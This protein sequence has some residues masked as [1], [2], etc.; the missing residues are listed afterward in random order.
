MV[1]MVE[2]FNHL[3][4]NADLVL[5]AT[6]PGGWVDNG[7]DKA[8]EWGGK[9]AVFLGTCCFIAALWFLS[10]IIL[11]KSKRALFAGLCL[12]ACVV[13]GVLVWGGMEFLQ[14]VGNGGFNGVKDL[15]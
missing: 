5:G 11:T 12:A 2:T 4:M 10:R 13:G 8:K 9:I 1:D 3:T 15:K 6:D 7:T 14:S